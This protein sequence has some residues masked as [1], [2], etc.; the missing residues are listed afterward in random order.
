MDECIFQT[1]NMM[2]VVL[3]ELRVKL[4]V[5]VNPGS[6]KSREEL[7]IPNR[8]PKLPSYFG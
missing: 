7:V 4:C 8:E 2:V 3:I 1:E 5:P 6:Y